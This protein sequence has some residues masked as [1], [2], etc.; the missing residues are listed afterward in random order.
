MT[1]SIQIRN[2][3][4]ILKYLFS[5]LFQN[6][7][8]MVQAAGGDLLQI[9]G[10]KEDLIQQVVQWANNSFFREDQL[11]AQLQAMGEERDQLVWERDLHR[12]GEARAGDLL[13]DSKTILER[14]MVS[15]KEPNSVI[16][17]CHAYITDRADIPNLD[18]ETPEEE[19]QLEQIEE[20]VEE[21]IPPG[22]DMVMD[23]EEENSGED[24]EDSGME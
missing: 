5:L 11:R 23:E 24:S 4:S 17:Q 2:L 16:A 19:I 6:H 22:P 8:A 20:Y 21:H 9:L 10:L 15:N 1:F 3:N 13:A 12:S 14:A 7:Q 18:P